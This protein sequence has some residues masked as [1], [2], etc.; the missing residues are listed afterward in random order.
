MK[1]T[2]WSSVKYLKKWK[3]SWNE[4]SCMKLQISVR[5]GKPCINIEK[6]RIII[7]TDKK[8]QN[9]MANRDI[10]KQLSEF[11]EIQQSQIRI[12]SG[13]SSRK[14]MIEIDLY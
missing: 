10:I 8:F 5:S 3:Q 6:D 13:F 1:M 14:K 11:F 4:R 9:N 2:G 7:T 12:I